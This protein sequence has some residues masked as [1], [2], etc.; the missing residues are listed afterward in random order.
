MFELYRMRVS[1]ICDIWVTQ[2]AF[3]YKEMSEIQ[4]IPIARTLE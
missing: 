3:A 1:Y 4:Q 2:V